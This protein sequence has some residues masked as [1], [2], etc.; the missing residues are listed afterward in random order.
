MK[1]ID[2][3]GNGIKIV[4]KAIL[5][6]IRIYSYNILLVMAFIAVLSK[7]LYWLIF[8]LISAVLIVGID[9][10]IVIS[11]IYKLIAVKSLSDII[12][13]MSDRTYN[14]KED[15]I[16]SIYKD[17]TECPDYNTEYCKTKCDK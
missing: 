11:S 14:G 15:G 2:D 17:K 13:S 1:I 8:I 12:N 7:D 10:K 9:M 3:V 4:I 6:F 16:C 5:K